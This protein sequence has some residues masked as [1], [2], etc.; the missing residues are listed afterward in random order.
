MISKY[1]GII[2]TIITLIISSN[3]ALH[4]IL[5][6]FIHH[7]YNINNIKRRIEINEV[8]LSSAARKSPI[9]LYTYTPTLPLLQPRS[10]HQHKKHCPHG[11]NPFLRFEKGHTVVKEKKMWIRPDVMSS[12]SSLK[13][14]KVSHD[15]E[16]LAV[17]C[18]SFQPLQ[19]SISTV[20]YWSYDHCWARKILL[21][22]FRGPP[23]SLL[24]TALH[25]RRE[26]NR[27]T[28]SYYST[29][30]CLVGVMEL[31]RA[32]EQSTLHFIIFFQK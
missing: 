20:P 7:S 3:T 30:L 28:V 11:K 5:S 8:S 24:T 21:H 17:S 1:K 14:Y 10:L 26:V 16:L 18:C 23:S 9:R 27:L 12:S 25:D 15:A 4:I 6:S 2:I 31:Y 13:D 22:N 32:D 29:V 19:F